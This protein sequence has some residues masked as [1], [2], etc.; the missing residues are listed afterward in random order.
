LNL[1]NR[2]AAPLL[3][4]RKK[5]RG[6]TRKE[7]VKCWSYGEIFIFVSPSV[8]ER[9]SE[10]GGEVRSREFG[11]ASSERNG[12]EEAVGYRKKKSLGRTSYYSRSGKTKA[13][14]ACATASRG[15]A[16]GC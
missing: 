16:V 10:E 9:E 14:G 4:L 3:F 2:G 6:D 8:G 12:K 5:K 15:R 13:M 11:D 7:D 1:V